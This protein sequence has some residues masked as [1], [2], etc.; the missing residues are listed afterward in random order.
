[1]PIQ[2]T[3]LRGFAA[4]L[5]LI[6]GIIVAV[7]GRRRYVGGALARGKLKSA[8]GDYSVYV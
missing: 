6:D 2:L 1:M 7:F 5:T 8:C 4:W 3:V